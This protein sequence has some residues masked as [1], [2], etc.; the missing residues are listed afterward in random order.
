[1]RIPA[2]GVCH[3]LNQPAEA[4]ESLHPSSFQIDQYANTV[5]QNLLMNPLPVVVHKMHRPDF[6]QE[7]AVIDLG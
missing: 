5:W 2:Q 7:I 6:P 3:D 1:M 4:V